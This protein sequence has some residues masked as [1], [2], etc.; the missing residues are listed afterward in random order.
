MM[1]TRSSEMINETVRNEWSCCRKTCSVRWH[2]W[3]ES[4]LQWQRGREGGREKVK[5][6]RTNTD[7]SVRFQLCSSYPEKPTSW[8]DNNV[9]V[10][11]VSFNAQ[12]GNWAVMHWRGLWLKMK[13]TF[14]TFK[15]KKFY[16]VIVLKA[17]LHSGKTLAN[18]PVTYIQSEL[19]CSE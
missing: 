5:K 6:Q 13:M 15:K 1:S 12:S 11:S 19:E 2:A 8:Q 3:P 9:S 16:D 4:A 7:K 18:I 10:P 14:L 17:A